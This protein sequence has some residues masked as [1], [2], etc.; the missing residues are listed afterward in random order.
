M[1]IYWES[2][3]TS[4]VVRYGV[5][6][7]KGFSQRHFLWIARAAEAGAPVALTA[8]AKIFS[9]PEADAAEKE[10]IAKGARVVETYADLLALRDVIDIVTLPVGINLHA[11]LAEQ[12]LRAGF[13]VYMEKPAAGTVAEVAGLMAAERETGR[14]VLV[15]FQTMYQP[16]TWL[17]KR[18]LLGG[19]VG[20]VNKIVVTVAWPRAMS[21]YRRN[22]WAGKVEVD[23]CKIYD[24][25]MN[26]SAAHFLNAALF[27]AGATETDSAVPAT[28][29]AEL[30]RSSLIESADSVFCRVLT[31]EGVEVVFNSSQACRVDTPVRMDIHGAAGDIV[32]IDQEERYLAPWTVTDLHGNERREG[33]DLRRVEVF[34]RAAAA[35]RDP[36]FK[37]ASTLVTAGMHTAANEL[38]F[39]ASDIRTVPD[40]YVEREERG[41][42]D[43]LFAVKGMNEVLEA[44]RPG[45][46][47]PSE[48]G[49]LGWASPGGTV[50]GG[51]VTDLL[52]QL[53]R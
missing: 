37:E 34:E 9:D 31:R 1:N 7:V 32:I 16:S 30:Y 17:L 26:N 12:A 3:M 33:E 10:L 22:R 40:E 53:G 44:L 21:Y 8:A 36:S 18:K 14:R 4:Q 29:Q 52:A 24:C 15:G 25:P 28:V 41:N 51:P 23:G 20:R 50:S 35:F 6:G 38:A 19:E 43:E 5:V 39:M 2:H 13:P 11:S 45:G 42:G 47:L 27:L 46:L 48:L 49:G